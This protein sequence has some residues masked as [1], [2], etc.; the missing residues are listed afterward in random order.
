MSQLSQLSQ[1]KYALGVPG[2]GIHV[3]VGGVA[4]MDFAFTFLAAI[5]FAYL[6]GESYLTS[7]VLLFLLGFFFHIIFNVPTTI[8]TSLGI[9][10]PDIPLR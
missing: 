6:S 9:V 10:R 8:T 7:F 2:Q 3:H 1:C 4:I 5:P